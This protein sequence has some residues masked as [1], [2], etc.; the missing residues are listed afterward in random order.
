MYWHQRPRIR[1][2][3]TWLRRAFQQRKITKGS[4]KDHA[5]VF[6]SEL[7]SRHILRERRWID[8][9][10]QELI[11]P[12]AR[13]DQADQISQH[14]FSNDTSIQDAET[15]AS[16]LFSNIEKLCQ[17]ESFDKEHSLIKA[18]IADTFGLWKKARTRSA[19]KSLLH[20][21]FSYQTKDRN[22]TEKALLFLSR[23]YN[24]ARTFVEA[25][26]TLPS[27][28]SVECVPIAN[29]TPKSHHS[30]RTAV[31]SPLE[32]AQ[33]LDLVVKQSAWLEYLDSNRSRFATTRREKQIKFCVHA[34]LQAV[35]HYNHDLR[36]SKAWSV[37]PY[38]GCSKRCCFLCYYFIL[39][40]GCFGVRGTHETIFYRW[41]IP[42]KDLST[43]IEQT[44]SIHAA[45]K[46]LLDMLKVLLGELFSMLFPLHQQVQLP[47]SSHALSSATFYLETE[48]A[49]LGR[50]KKELQ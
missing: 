22:D 31:R 5:A 6:A 36:K 1:T 13:T 40:H 46:R 47:Q 48:L 8:H 10:G 12:M 25:A 34:E 21:R 26:A 17:A 27:F 24:C 15:R 4:S 39:A 14:T 29:T 33:R 43:D 38:I 7:R 45:A 41:E 23:I 20:Q 50:P 16:N 11:I 35:H 30:R 9:T 42:S 19:I 32:A 2:Y 49:C 37:Y 18:L 3:L 44:E 28:R